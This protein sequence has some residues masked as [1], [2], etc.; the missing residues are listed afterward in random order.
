MR[1][2]LWMAAV[3]AFVVLPLKAQKTGNVAP[4]DTTTYLYMDSLFQQLPEVMVRGERPIAKISKGTLV[5]DLPR[6]LEQQP[7]DNA[8]ETL[9]KLPGVRT[10]EDVLML[11]MPMMINA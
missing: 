8:F 10:N 2:I 9:T 11:L 7:A 4:K 5:Y 6:L 1:R 3:S